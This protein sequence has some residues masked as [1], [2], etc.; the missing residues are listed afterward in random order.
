MISNFTNY[1]TLALLSAK[2]IH[3]SFH[4]RSNREKNFPLI[5]WHQKYKSFPFRS[6]T[7]S[8]RR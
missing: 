4:L 2:A 1:S 3:Q 8:A 5:L 6:F 7:L